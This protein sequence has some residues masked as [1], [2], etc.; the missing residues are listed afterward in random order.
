MK[1]LLTGIA[2]FAGSHLAELLVKRGNEVF[3][4][5]LPGENLN[6][7]QKIKPNLHLSKCDVTRLD[8]FSRLVKRVKPDQ[9]YHLASLTSV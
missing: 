1:V 2:G 5:L 9:V 3:G 6:N 4:T 8:Q 7:I